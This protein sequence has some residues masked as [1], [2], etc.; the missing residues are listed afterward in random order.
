MKRL[1]DAW[2][3]YWF[4]TT[5]T[6]SLSISR[7]VAV[8]AQL[9]WFFPD[10]GYNLNMA[11]KNTEFIDPQPLIRAIAA[12][13]P[14][15]VFFTP[16][17]ITTI[18]WTTVAA[19][20]TALLGLFTRTSIFVFAVGVWFFVSHQYSYADHHHP[21]AVFCIFLL[22]LAFAPSGASLSIDALLRRRATA[23][24]RRTAGQFETTDTAMWPLKLAHVL[25]AMTYLS[26]GAT[27]MIDG[28]LAW[29]NGYTL[30]AYTFNDAI[31]R[32]YPV[33]IWMGQQYGLSVLLSVVTV[34]FE[35]FFFLSLFFPRIAPFFFITGIFFQI[36][37][38]LSAGHPFFGH[39]VLL[40]LLLFFITPRWWRDPPWSYVLRFTRTPESAPA[41]ARG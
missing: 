12:V 33:G 8:A 39:I 40:V 19:G 25:L 29:M 23:G 2:N 16:A 22:A 34:F 37:L 10:L 1:V 28:G 20:L 32:G 4:P 6:V 9:F 24:A 11:E 14:R 31:A 21:E 7:V 30:Q 41:S 18:Y 15:D 26:T 27:K 13:V 17:V 38:Y 35:L 5:T 3:N 36:G